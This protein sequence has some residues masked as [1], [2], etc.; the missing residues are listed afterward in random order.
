MNIKNYRKSFLAMLLAIVM[1]TSFI[2]PVMADTTKTEPENM[3]IDIQ[4]IN[5][6]FSNITILGYGGWDD[7]T[8][9]NGG[10]LLGPNHSKVYVDVKLT[11]PSDAQYCVYV[12]STDGTY[13]TP[14]QY[15][16]G[17][18]TFSFDLYQDAYGTPKKDYRVAIENEESHPI[19]LTFSITSGN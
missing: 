2:L 18:D 4:S 13:D 11:N 3:P 7:Y 5:K 8:F 15:G 10:G 12:Y 6:T 17:T 1:S 14:K 16:A 9:N 19:V